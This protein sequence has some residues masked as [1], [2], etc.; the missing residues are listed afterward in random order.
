MR[1]KIALEEHFAIDLTIEQSR[2]YAPPVFWERLKS[3][4]MDLEQQRLE[5]M[6]QGGVEYAIQSLN[7][8]G[9]QGIPDAKEAIYVAK[10]ANDVL[11]EH[12]ARHPTRL[13]GFAALPMQDPDAAARELERCVN[14]LGFHGFMVNGFSQ[15]GDAETVAYYDAPRYADFWASAAALGKPFY[16]HPRDPLPSRE[17]I[18]DGFPWLGAATWAFAVETSIHALRLMTSGLFDRNPGLQ[19]ILGHLGEGI[20]FNIWRVDHILEK[21]PRGLPCQR[22][23]GEYLRENVHVTTSG[24]FRTQTLL[25]TMLEMGSDRIMYSVDYPFET[26]DEAA[27]WFDACS[28]SETDRVKIGRDN[29][30]RLFGLE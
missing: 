14:E 28:I 7:S 21:A 11:A 19:M 18:Y 5:R 17:P 24:N 29:A 6:E 4:L 8:P 27:Q 10:R 1:N 23:V 13:G 3:N 15:V 22:T 26:H 2:A 12:V 25:S 20:P 9:I 30:R 16:M